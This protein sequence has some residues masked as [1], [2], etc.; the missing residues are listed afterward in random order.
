MVTHAESSGPFPPW[1]TRLLVNL[2][3]QWYLLLRFSIRRLLCFTRLLRGRILLLEADNTLKIISLYRFRSSADSHHDNVDDDDDNKESG[4]QSDPQPLSTSTTSTSS[5]LLIL[6][7]IRLNGSGRGLLMDCNWS[8]FSNGCCSSCSS[9]SSSCSSSSSWRCCSRSSG[10]RGGCCRDWW[11][12]RRRH[13]YNSFV[14]AFI[15]CQ[16]MLTRF[17]LRAE[18]LKL[19]RC[20]HRFAVGCVDYPFLIDTRDISDHSPCIRWRSPRCSL[21]SLW[22]WRRKV[23]SLLQLGLRIFTRNGVTSNEGLQRRN[24]IRSIGIIN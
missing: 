3:H 24:A 14:L 9:C 17:R 1:I 15:I 20:S 8:L 12:D 5:F 2:S 11:N 6:P 13:N 4:T 19:W 22:F 18:N 16:S 7:T 10:C 23:M 21:I